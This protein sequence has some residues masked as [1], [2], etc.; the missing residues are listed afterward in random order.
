[1]NCTI[2]V[3]DDEERNLRLLEAML[4][5]LGHTVVKAASGKECLEIA[6]GRRPD[7]ILLDVMMPGMDGFEVARKLKS[8]RHTQGVPVVMVTA[9]SDVADRVRALDAGADDF[10]TKPIDRTE[11]QARV[12]SLLK[13]RAYYDNLEKHQREL[14]ELLDK[15]L[16]GSTNILVEILSATNPAAFRQSA[17]ILPLCRRIF[18]KLRLRDNW[19]T[20]L[21]IMLAPIGGFA[22]PAAVLEKAYSGKNLSEAE[23]LQFYSLATVGKSLLEKLPRLGGV[24]EAIAYQF[25]GFDGSG[26]PEDGVAGDDLPLGARI[27]RIVFDYDLLCQREGTEA[28][29]LKYMRANKVCYDSAIF[30][31]FAAEA[32]V[33]AQQR[34]SKSVPIG[35]LTTGMVLAEDLMD[36]TGKLLMAKGHV[37]TDVAK[38]RLANYYR[39]NK[40]KGAILVL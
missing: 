38:A 37:V 25:K 16:K 34:A 23:Q 9:L 33:L 27:M 30:D 20:E 14:K 2:L 21:A 24:A 5:P 1:M 32:V 13:V 11:L 15:T 35:E 10:L 8:S 7:L 17:R 36:E 12:K 28:K 18:H 40:I 29:A 6:W 26:Y 4:T 19:Q 22:V 39:F 31:I 3:V